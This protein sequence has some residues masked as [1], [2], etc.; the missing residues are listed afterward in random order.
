LVTLFPHVSHFVACNLVIQE[1]CAKECTGTTNNSSDPTNKVLMNWSLNITLTTTTTT[2]NSD[3]NQ[4]WPSP[5][6]ATISHPLYNGHYGGGWWQ[7]EERKKP[8][9]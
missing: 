4:V 5:L 1:E 2:Q 3:L 8:H 7:A 9:S 6:P